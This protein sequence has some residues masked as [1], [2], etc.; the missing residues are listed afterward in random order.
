MLKT[1]AMSGGGED[2]LEHRHALERTGDLVGARQPPPAAFRGRNFGHVLVEK[3]DPPFCRRV[4]ADQDAEQGGLAGAVRANDADRLA[5]A[6]GKVDPVEH[7][8]SAEAL[9][10][11]F[12]VKQRA[13]HTRAGQL[14]RL[15]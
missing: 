9:R 10:Q 11:A 13:V 1:G 7:H 2:V 5:G 4:G 14:R 15:L 6:D 8:E 12:R 3:A